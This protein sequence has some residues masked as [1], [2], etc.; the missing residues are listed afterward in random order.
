MKRQKYIIQKLCTKIDFYEQIEKYG[1]KGFIEREEWSYRLTVDFINK[2]SNDEIRIINTLDG[3]KVF[4][5]RTLAKGGGS[6][7]MWHI[8]KAFSKYNAKRVLAYKIYKFSINFYRFMKENYIHL[9]GVAYYVGLIDRIE[10][11]EF[12]LKNQLEE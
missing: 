7:E 10:P 11:S 8:R 12:Y 1:I 2:V 9:D 6:L 3:E 5:H 4:M